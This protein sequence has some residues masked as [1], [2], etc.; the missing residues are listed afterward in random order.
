MAKVLKIFQDKDT[1]KIY[2]PGDSYEGNSKRIAFLV[3]KG[4]L[5]DE[6]EQ[7]SGE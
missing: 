2:K 3:K 7:K 4:F 1:K 6:K 5:E